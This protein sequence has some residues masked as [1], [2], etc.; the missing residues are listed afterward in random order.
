MLLRL[1]SF[2]R[3][4]VFDKRGTGLSDR[5]PTSAADARGA[6]GRRAR[7]AWTRRARAG[8]RLR[9]VGGR[10][11]EHALRRD[12]PR[13]HAPRSSR[14]GST[15]NGSGARTIRG[16]RGRRRARPRSRRPSASGGTSTSSGVVPGAS[17]EL[18]ERLAALHAALGEPRRGGRAP[19]DEHARSTCATSLP[20]IR[21]PTLMLQRVGDR[22]V[23]IDEAR[24]I[25][26][27]HPGR[28]P[29]RA[30]GR[31][32][33]A[34]ARRDR[35]VSRR[36]RGVLD[37]R[38]A[39]PRARPS[40]RNGRVHRSRRLD[41]APPCVLGDE[42]WREL[43]DAPP[44]ARAARARA[45]SRHRGRHGGRRLHG[46][47]RRAGARDSVRLRDRRGASERAR[48]RRARRH[49]HGRVRAAS[50]RRSPGSP[51]TP[52]RASQ[53]WRGPGEVARLLRPCTISSRARAS[54]SAIVAVPS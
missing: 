5:V 35:A 28:A 30:P 10:Q 27:A 7:G 26:D 2:A 43:L 16:R 12:V 24:W 21:V 49:S 37:R 20:T 11:H 36:D 45:P 53:R 47:L 25:A 4:I 50:A 19:A 29:R 51:C 42:Q 32:A 38:P 22:D 13:P 14:S 34:L 41:R 6:H 33:P 8:R 44:R 40:A 17:A 1:G 18:S 3:V 52:A 9:R 31:H 15:R 39:D 46:A 48:P 23:H 54:S